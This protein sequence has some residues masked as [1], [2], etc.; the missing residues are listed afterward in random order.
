MPHRFS[1]SAAGQDSM[2]SILQLTCHISTGTQA[3][4]RKYLPGIQSWLEDAHLDNIQPPFVLDVS[5]S[6]WPDLDIDAVFSANT[7]H[8]MHWHNV[9]A[10]FAGVGKALSKGGKFLLYGPFN[11]NQQYTSESNERFDQWLKSRDPQSGIKH[12]E[13]LLALATNAGM[14]LKNDYEMPANN[15]ILHWEKD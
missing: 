5:E 10:L 15:R 2:Q 4:A 7:A 13:D 3:I 8:I 6:S 12:F 9:E 14:S 1:R 11:Y